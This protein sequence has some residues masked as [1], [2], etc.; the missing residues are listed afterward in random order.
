[1]YQKAKK[2]KALKGELDSTFKEI[3]KWVKLSEDPKFS[4]L[5][6]DNQKLLGNLSVLLKYTK[7]N[8]TESN[9][10][11]N[12]QSLIDLLKEL[13]WNNWVTYYQNRLLIEFPDDY[14]LL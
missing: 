10:K 2:K 8:L 12:Y 13:N 9:N 6:L 11:E 1:V 5:Y 4:K 3:G 7:K 14:P